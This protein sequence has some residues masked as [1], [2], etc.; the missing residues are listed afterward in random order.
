MAN[1]YP[2]RHLGV[3]LPQNDE[4]SYAAE[5]HP[6]GAS[7]TC[8][9][10]SPVVFASGLIVEGAAPVTALWG[11]SLEA[12][13]NTT[14]ATIKVMPAFHGLRFFA[15]FL[16]TGDA[17]GDNAIAAADLDAAGFE[18]FKANV[19]P[20]SSTAVWF[21]QDD[22]TAKAAKM[23][24]LRTDWALPNKIINYG[25]V[26]VGDIN[27]RVQFTVLDAVRKYDVA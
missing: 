12:G 22:A 6:E 1:T 17:G 8:V 10:G 16:A 26:S 14:G 5:Y 4:L 25:Q 27:A 15:N 3:W 20:P 19:L 23:A 24:S 21:V 7:V 2:I 11:F 18:I 9:K 13:H